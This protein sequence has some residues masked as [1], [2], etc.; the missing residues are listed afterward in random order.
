MH[1]TQTQLIIAGWRFLTHKMTHEMRDA[2]TKETG[3]GKCG[4]SLQE[5]EGE[6][7]E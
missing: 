1:H 4:Q 5:G 6:E 3:W 7:E 2:R